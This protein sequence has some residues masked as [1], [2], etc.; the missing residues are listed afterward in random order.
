M[1]LWP[2]SGDRRLSK[3]IESQAEFQVLAEQRLVKAKALLDLEKWD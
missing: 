1:N 2:A 3:L